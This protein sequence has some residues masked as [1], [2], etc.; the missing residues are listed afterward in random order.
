M[1]FDRIVEIWMMSIEGR[2]GDVEGFADDPK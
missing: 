1:A 2:G